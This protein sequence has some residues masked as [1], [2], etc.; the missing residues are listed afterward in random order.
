MDD[1]AY[2]PVLDWFARGSRVEITDAMGSAEYARALEQVPGLRAIAEVL[3][4][5]V[6]PEVV[7]DVVVAE[8]IG[9]GENVA[10]TLDLLD[11]A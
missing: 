5:G 1:T 9:A 6:A 2:K 8:R 4:R 10:E 3:V 11:A 7:G